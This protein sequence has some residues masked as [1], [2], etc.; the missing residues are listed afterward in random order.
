MLDAL[1]IFS[2]ILA[3]AGIGFFSVDLLPNTALAQVS[4]R[5]GLSLVT[6]GFGALIGMAFGLVAQT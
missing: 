1:I 3:G 4:N 5:E 2:F 6:A